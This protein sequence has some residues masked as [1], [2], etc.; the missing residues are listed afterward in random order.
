MAQ[1]SSFMWF[2]LSKSEWPWPVKVTEVKYNCINGP[3]L[4]TF[5]L[6]INSNI[7]SNSAPFRDIR[8]QNQSDLLFDLSRSVKV[9]CNNLIRFPIYI[10]SYRCLL[11]THGLTMLTRLLYHINSAL[12]GFQNDY[13]IRFPNLSDLL[14]WPFT[15]TQNKISNVIALPI[16][17]FL[18][19]F[20][21]NIWPAP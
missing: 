15:V 5:L 18:L 9:I 1:P 12:C 10:L 8:L 4:Y 17:G 16:Y 14:P 21:S 2:D 3:P 13:G 19:M 6:I 20:N 7:W 11:V